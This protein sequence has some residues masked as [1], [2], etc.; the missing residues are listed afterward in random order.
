[1]I[2]TNTGHGHVWERP[3][4]LKA[5][6]GGPGM[7][8]V[9][10]ADQADFR[11]GLIPPVPRPSK[12]P[13]ETVLADWL[14]RPRDRLLDD[15]ERIHKQHGFLFVTPDFYVMGRPVRKYAPL[16]QI[17]DVNHRFEAST[18]DTWF[19]FQLAG[20]MTK[21][22]RI[23]PWELPWMCWTRDNDPQQELM[24]FETRRLMRL[25]GVNQ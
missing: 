8:R 14:A 18:C 17:L 16:E 20:D 7:C 13:Y 2:G 9:C 11:A 21:A 5:R 10:A 22:W 15:Y 1:M 24:F 3:D 19:I 4:G 12:S 23:L 25:T 6:C